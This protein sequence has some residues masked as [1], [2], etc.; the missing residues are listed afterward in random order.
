VAEAC[1]TRLSASWGAPTVIQ[2]LD[3]G[4]FTAGVS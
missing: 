1:A 2:T 3:P 4:Y